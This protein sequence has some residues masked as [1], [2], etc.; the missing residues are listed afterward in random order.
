MC[1]IDT[2]PHESSL[3]FATL[4]EYLSLS[5]INFAKALHIAFWPG[6]IVELGTSPLSSL[7][8]TLDADMYTSITGRVSCALCHS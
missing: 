4:I 5:M 2:D 6:C 7:D 1:A 8:V 3:A